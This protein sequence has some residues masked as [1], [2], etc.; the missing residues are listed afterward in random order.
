[1]SYY[2]GTLKRKNTLVIQARRY[3]D[4]L[5][6]ELYDYWGERQITKKELRS[7]RYQIL[8]YLKKSRPEVYGNLRYAIVE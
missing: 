7:R 5:S 8:D 6:C 1:M 2:I 4:N 3:L